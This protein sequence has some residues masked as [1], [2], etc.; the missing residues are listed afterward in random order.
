MLLGSRHTRIAHS[1]TA[2]HSDRTMIVVAP[3]D[4]NFDEAS[5]ILPL[6][7]VMEASGIEPLTS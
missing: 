3:S 5:D 1:E 4:P 7:R 2:L 6:H